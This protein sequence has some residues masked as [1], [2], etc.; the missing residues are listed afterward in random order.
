MENKIILHDCVKCGNSFWNKTKD[1]NTCE[2]CK[3]SI[4]L[5]TVSLPDKD[6]I[7][8]KQ[9]WCDFCGELHEGNCS[10]NAKKRIANL[11]KQ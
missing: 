11:K 8:Q 6:A 9:E 5:Q 1:D 3:S 10:D 4:N 7:I 2:S